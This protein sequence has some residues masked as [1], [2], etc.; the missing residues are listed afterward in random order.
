[1]SKATSSIPCVGRTVIWIV[2]II[3]QSVIF[4][5]SIHSYLHTHRFPYLL[6]IINSFYNHIKPHTWMFG[7][8]FCKITS[9]NWHDLPVFFAPESND[10]SVEFVFKYL[11]CCCKRSG[12]ACVMLHSSGKRTLRPAYAKGL[13]SHSVLSLSPD[14]KK[15][16]RNLWWWSKPWMAETDKF[17][18]GVKYLL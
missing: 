13:I 8:K 15:V 16:F 14:V 11:S 4:N 10:T 7:M 6:M 12:P 9:R 3:N 2:I 5:T 17:S 1:M 18:F